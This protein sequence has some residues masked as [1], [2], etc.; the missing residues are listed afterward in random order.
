[1]FSNHQCAFDTILMESI[2]PIGATEIGAIDPVD[3]LMTVPPS[4]TFRIIH[5]MMVMH[6]FDFLGGING[7]RQ[8]ERNAVFD[9]SA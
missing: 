8:I 9:R 3:L 6:F 7:M 4:Q 2:A 5:R 1:M